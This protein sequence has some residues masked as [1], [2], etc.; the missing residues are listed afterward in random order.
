MS[1]QDI[2]KIIKN[3]G[4]GVFPTD[5]LYGIVA[6]ALVAKSV[7]RIYD[8]KSRNETKPF[9]I[10]ISNISDL[11]KFGIKLTKDQ[12]QYL[13][14]VWPGPVSVI[15]PCALKKLQYLHRGTNSLAFRF[16]KN[17]K[18]LELISATGPLVAPSANPEGLKPAETISVAKKY[19][20]DKV[21]FYVSGGRKEGKPSTIVSMV[22]GAPVVLRK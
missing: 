18:I 13:D 7:E 1:Q 22:S 9:I 2:V 15:L 20:G 3:G 12:S 11:S 8:I 5:T 21:D 6:D 19:F 14:S 4:V 17:K 16:P 10:L